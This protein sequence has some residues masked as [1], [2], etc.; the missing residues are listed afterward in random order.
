MKISSS[1]LIREALAEVFFLFSKFRL[2]LIKIYEKVSTINNKLK[3]K[4]HKSPASFSQ[5]GYVNFFQVRIVLDF[6]IYASIYNI[7]GTLS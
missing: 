6:E 4:S 3:V 1:P 2:L 5:K 7:F